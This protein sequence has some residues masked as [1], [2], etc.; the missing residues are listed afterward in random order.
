M[1]KKETQE[2]RC[3]KSLERL[4]T[5]FGSLE[6]YDYREDIKREMNEEK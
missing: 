3:R 4:V 5:L 2:Q 1:Y 6:K